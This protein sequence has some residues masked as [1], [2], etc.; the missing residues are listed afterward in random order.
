VTASGCGWRTTKSVHPGFT[1]RIPHSHYYRPYYKNDP[2]R[3]AACPLTIHGLLH[4]AWGIR[5]AGPVWTYWAFAMERH[6]NTLLQSIK[7]GRHPYASITSFVITTAQLTQIR[8]LYDL[9]EELFLNPDR[10]ESGIVHNLCNVLP[11]SSLLVT[12][13]P[14]LYRSRVHTHRSPMV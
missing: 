9:H 5:V 3:L 12:Y 1:L 8:L 10:K 14:N 7:S 11:M 13:Q 6:C 4:I 2:T